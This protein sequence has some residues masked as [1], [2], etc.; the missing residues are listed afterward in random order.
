MKLYTQKYKNAYSI[1]PALTFW[2][3]TEGF[4]LTL[5]WGNRAITLMVIRKDEHENF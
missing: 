5:S 1:L 3:F 2:P 4:F